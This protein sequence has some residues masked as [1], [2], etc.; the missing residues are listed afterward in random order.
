MCCVLFVESSYG[1][2]HD[3]HQAQLEK[4]YQFTVREAVAELKSGKCIG[5]HLTLIGKAKAVEAI[6]DLEVL[7]ARTEDELDKL[8]IAQVLVQLGDKND[9]YWDYL[10]RQAT[11]VIESDAPSP[12]RFDSEG[13]GIPGSAPSPEFAAWAKAHKLDPGEEAANAVYLYP[14]RILLLGASD[15]KRAIPLLRR[16]L[17]SSNYF[18]E[19]IAAEGLAENHDDAS[20]PMIIEACR[21][22][23]AEAAAAIATFSLVYFDDPRAQSAV[24]QYLPKEQAKIFREGRAMGRTPWD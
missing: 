2:D 7:F 14:G 23:P 22:A 9:R 11:A 19:T 17:L 21:R 1:Q 15:D 10:V 6:P 3:T 20:I 24:D 12:A 8:E 4:R 16:A 18:V 13:K 5:V